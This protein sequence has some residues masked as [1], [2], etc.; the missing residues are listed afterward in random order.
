VTAAAVLPPVS[1][2]DK[3]TVSDLSK[4]VVEGASVPPPFFLQLKGS[5][6]A[7]RFLAQEVYIKSSLGSLLSTENLEVVEE[8]I[9]LDDWENL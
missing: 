8:D 6:V 7:I 5:F 1:L 4:S 2:S 9:V 3:K